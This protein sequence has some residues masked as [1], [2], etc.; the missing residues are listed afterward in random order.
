MK[1]TMLA[2]VLLLGGTLPA[3]ADGC[4]ICLQGSGCGQYCRYVGRDDADNRRKCFQANC[5]IAG[6][7]SCPVGVNVRTCSAE[8]PLQRLRELAALAEERAQ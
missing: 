2:L 8:R 1:R 6:T 3:L 5:K 4:Y 7:A